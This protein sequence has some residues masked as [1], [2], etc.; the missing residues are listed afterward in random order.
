VR[1]SAEPERQPQ[2][3]EETTCCVVNVGVVKVSPGGACQDAGGV[4]STTTG[5][6]SKTP[7]AGP[8]DW[9]LFAVVD[10]PRCG[11]RAPPT[12]QGLFAR[13]SDARA[14]SAALGVVARPRR[15]RRPRRPGR[16]HRQARRHHPP[17]RRTASTNNTTEDPS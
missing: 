5:S 13:S 17:A 12:D 4:L 14:T 7:A 8:I 6:T 3:S 10:G 11:A 1:P 16:E 9:A 15:V 2:P